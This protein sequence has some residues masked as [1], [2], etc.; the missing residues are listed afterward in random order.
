MIPI[1]M[2]HPLPENKIELLLPIKVKLKALEQLAQKKLVGEFLEKEN[3][4]ETTHYAKIIGVELN[5]DPDYDLNMRVALLAKTR[6][7][8]D[9]VVALNIK[10]NFS[11][12]PESQELD[13]SK[14]HVESENLNWFADKLLSLTLNSL[15]K[16]KIL[17][18][19]K[20]LLQPKLH[21]AMDKI[22]QKLIQ[23]VEVKSGIELSGAVEKLTVNLLSFEEKDL[24]VQVSL[25]GELALEISEIDNLEL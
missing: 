16:K 6:L 20:V 4:G 13:I 19:S 5:A 2:P 10:I 1:T 22:N 21:K 23:T 14:Y 7:F 9:K 3:D 18:K 25:K 17:A 11:Y 24:L 8:K 15:L 12:N